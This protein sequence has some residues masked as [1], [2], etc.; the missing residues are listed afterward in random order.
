M[1]KAHLHTWLASQREPDK[2]L[3]EAAEAGFW[4]WTNTVF[5]F[6]RQFLLAL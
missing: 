1:T 4:P 5:D 2:R 3:G 6:L